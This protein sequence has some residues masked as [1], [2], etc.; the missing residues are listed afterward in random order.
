ML[1]G[2]ANE[3]DRLR[4][5]RAGADAFFDKSDFAR[6]ALVDKLGELIMRSEPAEL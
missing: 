6:G 3:E 2:V 5:E 4:A 1:S